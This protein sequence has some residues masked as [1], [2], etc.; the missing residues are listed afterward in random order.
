M[1]N[2]ENKPKKETLSEYI[3]REYPNIWEEYQEHKQTKRRNWYRDYFKRRYVIV[4]R[5]VSDDFNTNK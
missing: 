5:I 3:K 4:D 2:Q 1:D